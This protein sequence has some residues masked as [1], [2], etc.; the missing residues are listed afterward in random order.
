MTSSLKPYDNVHARFFDF[1]E[2]KEIGEEFISSLADAFVKYSSTV[3]APTAQNVFST[4]VRFLRWVLIHQ[5]QLPVF[6]STLRVNFR[7][8]PS[9]SWEQV[10]ALWRS[11]IVGEKSLSSIAKYNKLK[12]LNRFLKTLAQQGVIPKIYLLGAPRGLRTSRPTKTL[13]EVAKKQSVTNKKKLD[14]ALKAATESGMDL[15]VKRDFL[16]T[17]ASETGGIKGTA[18]EHAKALMRINADR[19]ATIRRCAERDFMEGLSIWEAGQAALKRCDLCWD[20]ISRRIGATRGEVWRHSVFP[21]NDPDISLSRLLKYF[22][23]HPKFQGRTVFHTSGSYK[24]GVG[25]ELSRFGGAECVQGYLFPTVGL[26]IAVIV[27]VLCDTGANVSVARSL[28]IDCLEDSENPGYK[29]IKG[30]KMRANGKL[31][32]DELPVI[33]PHHEISCVQA[34][35]AY[36]RMSKLMRTL[37]SQNDS[38]TLFL[39]AKNGVRAVL[40]I[41]WSKGFQNFRKRHDELAHLPI[42]GKMIRPSLLMQAAFQNEAGIVAAATLADHRSLQSTWGYVSRYPTRVVWE[43]MVREFQS[44]FQA[45]SIHTIKGAAKKLGLSAKQVKKLFTSACRTGLGVA[46]RDP[47]GGLQPNTEKGKNCT[48]LENC[49]TC[50]NQIVVATVENLRD[51]ILF[52]H[53]LECNRKEWETRRPERWT[54][55]WLPW[56][57]FTQVVIELAQRGRTASH[58]VKARIVAERMIT[59]NEFNLPP[60]W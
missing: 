24:P 21:P 51:L 16:N 50:P 41:T 5:D 15:Q 28:S 13:A 8:C 38:R 23:E 37:A 45:V 2:F 39:N 18:D 20:E 19:L 11:S 46:C 47:R 44:L 31:V 40:D 27:L 30:K 9:S 17:L 58:F 4:A 42:Q 59:Q 52:N 1:T 29:T 22:A 53:H 3:A 48:K 57:V 35:L 33:D 54:R 43:R 7:Q 60:L 49:P 14:N 36:Q 34:I 32:V 26:T 6:S 12:T 10:I 25:M 55:I 56:L